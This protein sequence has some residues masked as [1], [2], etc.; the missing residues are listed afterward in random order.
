MQGQ[1]QQVEVLVLALEQYSKY[2]YKLIYLKTLIMNKILKIIYLVFLLGFFFQCDS[3]IEDNFIDPSKTTT[4]SSE[5]L[6]T[7]VFERAKNYYM[8]YYQRHFVFTN[9]SVGFY[10]QT[11]GWVNGTKQYLPGS[12]TEDRWNNYYETL[13]QFRE[14]EDVYVA[15]GDENKRIFL[16]AAKIF[17]YDQ[18]Q[19]VVDMWGD[20]PWS[21]AGKLKSSG[22]NLDEAKAKYDAA[23]DIYNTMIVELEKIADELSSIKITAIDQ[24]SFNKQDII[25]GGDVELWRKYCNSLRVR[26][27][28]GLCRNSDF[29]EMAKEEIGKI[30]A[31]PEKYPLIS[32]LSDEVVVEA[33]GTLTHDNQGERG[34]RGC[35]ESWGTDNLAPYKMVEVMREGEDP[36]L[37]ILFAPNIDGEYIGLDPMLNAAEQNRLIND[38]KVARYDTTT[39]SRNIYVPGI[40]ISAAEVQFMLAEAVEYLGVSG[41]AEEAYNKG[42]DLAIRQLYAINNLSTEGEVTPLDESSIA[43]YITNSNMNWNSSPNKLELIATQKWIHYNYLQPERAWTEIRRTNFPKLDFL[44]DN[45]TLNARTVPNR[46]LYPASERYNLDNYMEVQKDDFLTTK[47]FWDID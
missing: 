29:K 21:E 15:K 43:E 38:A 20:I 23:E 5:F 47:I 25:N 28:I 17:M 19:Q 7:G 13:L 39:Y 30:L 6:M 46:L 34:I 44:P 35:L 24:A 31:N 4:T 37:E 45:N 3:M 26:L 32:D 27:C 2:Y 42:V 40:L 14:L 36:R 33:I 18:T 16:L 12:G 10:S 22:G 11:K 9:Q 8:P 41:S 1:V